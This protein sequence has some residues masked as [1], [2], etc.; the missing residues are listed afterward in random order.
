MK[1]EVS[2]DR[3]PNLGGWGAVQDPDRMPISRHCLSG[4][5]MWPALGPNRAIS[6][7]GV[8][9]TARHDLQVRA[10][11]RL[12]RTVSGANSD[13]TAVDHS[14]AG[15]RGPAALPRISVLRGSK[16]AAGG[17][18]GGGPFSFCPEGPR[19]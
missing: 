14:A 5:R 19:F 18:P 15:A 13:T 1:G 12:P 16:E 3:T 9:T 4:G 8:T 10:R 7:R 17:G 6:G 11:G 2:A